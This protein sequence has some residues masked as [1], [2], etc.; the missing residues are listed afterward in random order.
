MIT[1]YGLKSGQGVAPNIADHQLLGFDM[2]SEPL[3]ENILTFNGSAKN[4]II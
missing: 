1:Q 4:Y 2:L 3:S